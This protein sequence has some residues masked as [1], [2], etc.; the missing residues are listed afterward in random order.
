[1]LISKLLQTR[2]HVSTPTNWAH[3]CT[4]TT[5]RRPAFKTPLQKVPHWFT[6][7]VGAAEVRNE[8]KAT[9]A[10]SF[11]FIAGLSFFTRGHKLLSSFVVTASI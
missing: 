1:M 3:C 11:H 4:S 7:G 2:H 6:S 8:V 10:A 9:D 5:S